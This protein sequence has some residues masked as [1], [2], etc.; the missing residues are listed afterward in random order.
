MSTESSKQR[1]AVAMIVRNAERV[2][3]ACIA[4]VRPFVDEVDVYLAGESTDGTVELLDRLAAQP[5]PPIRF[6]QGEWRDDFAQARNRSLELVSP[7]IDWVLV[8][9]ADETF[10]GGA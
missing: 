9:D 10:E 3:D 2:L 5:G 7:D 4:S 8:L 6:E 1:I